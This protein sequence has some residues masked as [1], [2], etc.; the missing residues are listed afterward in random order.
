[1]SP[2][3]WSKASAPI[4]EFFGA[5]WKSERLD[6]ELARIGE[7]SNK[8]KDA[9]L[10][11]HSKSRA[12]VDQEQAQM[13]SHLHEHSQLGSGTVG[14]ARAPDASTLS[15]ADALCLAFKTACGIRREKDAPQDW[16]DVRARAVRWVAKGY[17]TT[18]IVAE[19][20]ATVARTGCI[21]PLN[22]FE[23]VFAT[24]VRQAARP[25]PLPGVA[26]VQRF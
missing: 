10:Q 12:T 16:G 8:R 22:Y 14:G 25:L 18:M 23:E 4:K 11:K 3:Q 13:H 5:D 2:K 15:E 20:K 21:K 1:M 9:A 7:I 26:D 24:A 6:L 17:S 19:T